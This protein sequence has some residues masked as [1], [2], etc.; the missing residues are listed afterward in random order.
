MEK[1]ILS[2]MQGN[3]KNFSQATNEIYKLTD[4]NHK[5]YPGYLQWF[6]GKSI[7][8]VFNKTG[9]M[10]FYLDGYQI[11]GLSILKKDSDEKKICTFM[12]SEDYR[13][14]GYSKLLLEE[15][16]KL[17]GTEKPVI[18]IPEFRIPEF[19]SIIDAYDWKQTGKIGNYF[20]PEYE[21]N[22]CSRILKK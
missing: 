13:K 11:V 2:E 1:F 20:S 8:R 3:G 7:P 12:I 10:L 22:S 16:F 15:S 21:F 9:D 14:K 19:Q 18:T 17:L 5:Q 6:Y 4:Y